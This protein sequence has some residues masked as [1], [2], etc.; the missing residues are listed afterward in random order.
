MQAALAR[1]VSF[2]EI[3]TD[4]LKG[5]LNQVFDVVNG[6]GTLWNLT[7]HLPVVGRLPD[8]PALPTFDLTPEI[9]KALQQLW[10][11][12]GLEHV[13]AAGAFASANADFETA[14]AALC[15]ARDSERDVL[16]PGCPRRLSR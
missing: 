5:S 10:D 13:E 6:P 9:S 2:S 7:N 8:A 16:R 14:V 15:A 12:H 3:S 4:I 11:D 1:D